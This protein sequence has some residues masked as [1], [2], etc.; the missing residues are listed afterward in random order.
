MELSADS[1]WNMT[2][3]AASGML[4]DACVEREELYCDSLVLYE[5]TSLKNVHCRKDGHDVYEYLKRSLNVAME[6]KV[7]HRE[8][9]F[10]SC[11]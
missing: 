3:V 2:L 7:L 1:K 8:G 5:L 6:K 11:V 4:T 9:V 10:V